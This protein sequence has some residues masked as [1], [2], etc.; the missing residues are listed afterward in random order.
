MPPYPSPSICARCTAR[1]QWQRSF[2]ITA[3]RQA[4]APE[5]PQFIYVP[6]SAQAPKPKPKPIKGILP[7]PRDIFPDRD[8]PKANSEY[9]DR[10][11]AEPK[12]R[13]EA[14]GLGAALVNW[15][16]EMSDIRRQNLRQGITELHDRKKR[17]TMTMARRSAAK[18]AMHMK[19]STAPDPI[20]EVLTS[21]SLHSSVKEMLRTSNAPGRTQKNSRT[22]VAHQKAKSQERKAQL[23][24]LYVHAQNFIV[25]EKQLNNEL[26]RVFG[27]DDYPIRWNGTGNSVWA[28]EAGP[29][30]TQ[31][32]LRLSDKEVNA[33]DDT[34]S[35]KRMRRLSEELT[36][37]KT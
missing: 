7:V 2:S 21:Q 20:D 32:M 4:V 9:L 25:S 19:K 24:K 3:S 33:T 29:M 30:T 22:F 26:D 34:I 23:H 10:A 13:K 1:L 11:A 27:S 8:G 6:E 12:S 18:M 35:Q 17:D 5:S 28:L 15:R 16:H 36:G 14:H 31:R 37:G